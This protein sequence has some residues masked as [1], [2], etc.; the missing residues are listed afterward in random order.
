[1]KKYFALILFV[2]STF[3]LKAQQEPI[4]VVFDVTSSD[5]KVHQSTMRHV[6]LM[7]SSY[8]ESEFEVVVYSGSIDMVLKSRSTV[9][10]NIIQYVDN[11]NVSFKVCSMTM[12]RKEIKESQLLSGVSIV[13]DGILEIVSKQAEGWGYIKE[14]N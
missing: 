5:P 12:K 1:M 7:A 2:F 6:N 13:P 9:A 3:I 11:D 10:D 14:A 8:P 4:K